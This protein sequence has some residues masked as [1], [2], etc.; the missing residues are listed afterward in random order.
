MESY[1][2]NEQQV[3]E[4]LLGFREMENHYTNQAFL[5]A[6]N[7]CLTL[8]SLS[9]NNNFS[10][11]IPPISANS[12]Y[13]NNYGSSHPTTLNHHHHHH[14]SFVCSSYASAFGDELSPPDFT[15]DSLSGGNLDAQTVPY[16]C[17]EAENRFFFQ[18]RS[19]ECV[20]KRVGGCE[21]GHRGSV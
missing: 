7:G 4:E 1:Y 21:P 2:T 18:R 5:D 3:L 6:V 19:R 11:I 12:R 10:S 17:P 9:S 20:P 14:Q 13:V 16:V 15:V 8:D